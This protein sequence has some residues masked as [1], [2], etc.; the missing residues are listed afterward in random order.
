M[1]IPKSAIAHAKEEYPKESCGVIVNG[2]YIK[3]RNVHPDPINHFRINDD[4]FMWA[5]DA[6]EIQAIIHSH[7]NLPATPSDH[8]IRQCKL[9]GVP[10]GIISIVDG[11]HRDSFWMA[12]NDV[13]P[14]IGRPYIWGLY[15]CLSIILDYY[16]Y[17]H[18]LDLGDFDRPVDWSKHKTPLYETGLSKNGFYKVDQPKNG[19]VILMQLS[20]DF[21]SHAAIYLESGRIEC[22][23]LG[24]PAPNSILHHEHGRS[25]K[26][27]TY[28]GYWL[29]KTVSIW[30]HKSLEQ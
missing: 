4:D 8:D 16:K 12:P 23:D 14:L 18:N 19:D 30:R 2:K 7:P 3:C 25:S 24:Y 1:R 11:E 9:S 6:G 29:E 20:G 5:S 28:G 17:E 13:T 22:Q 21:A 10:W 27:D 26:R 15:D